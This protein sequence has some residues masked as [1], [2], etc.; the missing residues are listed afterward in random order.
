MPR[1][2]ITRCPHCGSD[3]GI[4]TKHTL[5]NI[6]WGCGFGG[7]EQDNQEMYDEAQSVSGGRIAY[8]Q[9]CKKAICRFSTLEK[10]WKEQE[11]EANI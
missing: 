6:R 9:N 11:N 5:A 8:C 1:K 3:K 2:P 7:E 4:F 10:Q